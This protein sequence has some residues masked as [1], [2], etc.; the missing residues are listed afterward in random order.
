MTRRPTS[1]ALL[2]VALAASVLVTACGG[3]DTAAPDTVAPTVAITS[4][5]AGT[6]A[7]GAVTFT[8]TFS[9]DVGTSFTAEDI[10]VNG[11]TAGAFTRVSG[12]QATLVVTPAAGGTGS[13]SVSVAAAKFTDIANNP[14]AAVAALEQAYNTAVAAVSGNTGTCTTAP[15]IG[16][17]GATTGFV[18]FEG[19]GSA[20]IVDDPVDPTN[21]VAKLVKVPAGQPWA[22]ATV[23]TT[24]AA[25][26]TTDA[27]GFATSKVI[28]L[29]VYSPAVGEKIMLKV[30]TGPQGGGMEKEVLTTKANAWETL[31]FDFASPS[32]GTY[33]PTKVYKTISIF[34][35]FLTAVTADTA[36]YFDELKYAAATAAPASCGTTAPTC[37]PTTAIPAGAITVYSEASV[38]AGFNARPDWGQT[39]TYSEATLAG[40]KSLKYTFG[41]GGFGAPGAYEGL[42]WA[43]VNVSTKGKLHL[44]LWSADLS[45]L[46]I[47]LISAGKENAY[48]Q[49]I[50]PGSW[51]SVDIDLSNYT[52]ADKTAIIQLKIESATAGTVYIDNIHFWGTPTAAPAGTANPNALAGS[53]GPVTIPV[54]TAADSIGFAMSGDAVFAGDYEGPLDSNNNHALW[55]GAVT[56]GV[57]ANGNVGYFNDNALSNS[58]QKLEEN[59]WVASSLD[60]PGGVPSI[61]RYFI[62]T[63]PAATFTSSYMG[64][65]V[66]AP[67]NGT[68]NVSSYGS[69]KFRAWGP[70]EMY[71][72]N[73][74]NPTLEMTLAGAKVAGC[75]ATG[76][77]GTEIRKSFV[78]NQKIGAASTYKLSLAGWT[79]VG[80]CGADTPATAA[81]SVLAGLARVVLT[82][83]GNSFNFTN[84]NAG[85]TVVTYATG[86]NLGP[87]AFTNN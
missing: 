25:A 8:F 51:N 71:Q 63:A 55:A 15:C 57:A 87:I 58:A 22:G 39:V 44:D 52:A 20:T 36:Y 3:G 72:Q 11:G 2:A 17:E 48:V 4:S 50:T 37:A 16:F 33:D 75:T 53:A 19:L 42:E 35:K 70:A 29:R 18:A 26:Q 54:L 62:L 38:T 84:P 23:Y 31:S 34:P 10:V 9:E 68:V 27:I 14:N 67:G 69:I 21:K 76:S 59:G 45:S 80:V 73:N 65:Y 24:T 49:A 64:L 30:E 66:N 77:G 61:F 83:P 6:T 85:G 41:G 1:F 82:V 78:A 40:N 56:R 81:A 74:L 5:A 60:N 86:V 79:V 47:S 43:A 13:L 32:A 12:I 46:K 28:T 7:T